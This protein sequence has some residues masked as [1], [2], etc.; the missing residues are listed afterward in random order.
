MMSLPQGQL[1]NGLSNGEHIAW[2]YFLSNKDVVHILNR[3]FIVSYVKTESRCEAA[4][5]G[6]RKRVW[7]LGALSSVHRGLCIE[8]CA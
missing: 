4:W 1:G 3:M 5:C 2:I 7:D 6:R 8:G